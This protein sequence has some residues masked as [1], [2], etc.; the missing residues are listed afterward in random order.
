M[1]IA[2]SN[3]AASRLMTAGNLGSDAKKFS[4]SDDCE[5]RLT[6]NESATVAV[7]DDDARVREAFK[8]QLKTAGFHTE[9]YASAQEFLRSKEIY[10]FDCVV[11]DIYLPGLN[12]L[13]LQYEL[14][15]QAPYASVIFVTGHGDLT[16]AMSAVRNG[17][18]DFLEKPVDDE[19]LLS[20]VRTGADRSR[21]R[22]LSRQQRTEIEKAYG[23]LTPRERD[24][25]V[26]ITKGL[27][28]KQVAAELGITER[29]VKAHRGRVMNKMSAGSL[30]DL[31]R[32]AEI[33]R[34]HH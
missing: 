20:A 12:G 15:R 30:A 17:A 34:I 14:N 1:S 16:V 21:V 25:F 10:Q 23:S 2:R 11:A 6:A 19:A 26:L 9:A 27:L 18:V 4:G 22:R 29:T 31:V 7:V 24:A 3:F 13:Q 32:M 8:L 5:K 33:L 28:N